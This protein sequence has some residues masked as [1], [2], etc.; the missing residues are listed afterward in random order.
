MA[1]STVQQEKLDCSEHGNRPCSENER[2]LGVPA[3][4]YS[5]TAGTIFITVFGNL[6]MIISI[7][8]FR[9]L[10]TPTNFLILSMVVTDFLLGF[11]IMPYSVIRS[12]ENCWYFRLTFCKIHYSFDM[13]LSITSIFHLCSVAIDTFYAFCYPLHY[14]TKMTV[15]VTKRLLLLCWSVPGAFALGVVFS[16]AYADGIEGYD[17]SV[18][19]SSSCPVMFNKLRDTILFM[20]DFFTPGSMMVGIYGKIF[21]ITIKQTVTTQQSA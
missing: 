3:A 12:V 17:I 2:A 8:Y 6:A 14:S 4:V 5:F 1:S 16:E 11:I 9:Q 21:A 10:H 7:S 19:C 18:A 15:P 13:M 20:A